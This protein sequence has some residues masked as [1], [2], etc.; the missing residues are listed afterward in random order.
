MKN[1]ILSCVL[2]FGVTALRADVFSFSY[3]GTTLLNKTVTAAGSITADADGGGFYTIT[4]LSGI[5][6]GVTMN[7]FDPGINFFY[8]GVTTFG[9]FDFLLAGL[10][11]PD[12]LTFAG[13]SYSVV[14]PA[15]IS[16]GK[17]FQISKVP[18]TA[19]LS[20]L[21]S[22]GL[23]VWLVARKRSLKRQL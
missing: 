20:L 13:S 7:L 12:I 22:M 10:N 16:A 8:D 21:F 23:G 9:T 15:P 17:D 5:Q 11:T 3:T 1:L 19:T 18:E 4:D 14:G 2:L 6:N